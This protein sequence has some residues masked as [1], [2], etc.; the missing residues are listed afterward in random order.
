MDPSFAILP[1]GSI[2]AAI[3]H[4]RISGTDQFASSFTAKY[5]SRVL[6][7][8]AFVHNA[9]WDPILATS[10]TLDKL[11]EQLK[12]DNYSFSQLL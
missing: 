6:A 10:S 1:Y 12:E 5:G 11:I 3:Q 4:R 2:V 9:E 7:K 8:S